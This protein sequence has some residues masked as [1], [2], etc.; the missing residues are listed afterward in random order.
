MRHEYHEDYS[1]TFNR[2]SPAL[3]D[4]DYR[5]VAKRCVSN[6]SFADSAGIASNAAAA[7]TNIAVELA[8]IRLVIPCQ[9]GLPLDTDSSANWEASNGEYRFS[10]AQCGGCHSIYVVRATRR[11]YLSHDY[12]DRFTLHAPAPASTAE[13]ADAMG[14]EY[15]SAS[16]GHQPLLLESVTSRAEAALE[17]S[18]QEMREL[19]ADIDALASL[20]TTLRLQASSRWPA[21]VAVAN[22]VAAHGL[23]ALLLALQKHCFVRFGTSTSRWQQSHWASICASIADAHEIVRRHP[24]DV[25]PDSDQS[26]ST[27]N[28]DALTTLTRDDDLRG[29]IAEIDRLDDLD[30][31]GG[32]MKVIEQEFR[33]REPLRDPRE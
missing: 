30:D 15:P 12:R 16:F 8:P 22:L 27:E 23:E 21:S 26:T 18:N 33:A 7:R 31:L 5:Y 20:L 32:L 19:A 25:R 14:D 29:E 28:S 6:G 11:T 3:Q 4:G 9:C 13:S 24:L 17:S 2:I 10:Q 1:P